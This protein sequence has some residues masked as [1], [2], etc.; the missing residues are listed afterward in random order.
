MKILF[1]CESTDPTQ[2]DCD[3]RAEWTAAREAGFE[4]LVFDHGMLV[5]GEVERSLRSI[6][7][8]AGM[9]LH[10]S[11]MV[12]GAQYSSLYDALQMRGYQPLVTPAGYE[13]SHYLPLAYHLIAAYTADTVWNESDRVEDA[14]QL[15]AT[16]S[17]RDALIKDWVKSA[18]SR[19]RTGCFIPAGTSRSDF[20]KIFAV[21]RDER[22]KLFN[23]GVVLREFL[24]F[25]TSGIDMRGFPC[26]EETRLF[27]LQGNIVVE[28]NNDELLRQRS[29]WQSIARQFES[30][31]ISM[32]IAPLD[33][34][35]YRIVEVGDAGVS[36]LPM[37]IDPA[38]FFQNLRT[39]AP[40]S[41]RSAGQ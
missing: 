14:W 41:V 2:V 30:P 32:D 6:R 20:E 17:Q 28:P 27:F 13:Q 7:P 29:L 25:R 18:K 19:W 38:I 3:F 23:R 15:Y 37:G 39:Y 9:L 36:G 10:R 21:F 5:R 16:M 1:P 34:G 35:T 8:G 12:T 22:G 26:T 40:A 33:D 24:K 11:W 31:A 4:C